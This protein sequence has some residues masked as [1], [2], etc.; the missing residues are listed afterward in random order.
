MF[1][2]KMAD[3]SHNYPS[4]IDTSII[5]LNN[6]A[7]SVASRFISREAFRYC[8]LVFHGL[9]QPG[10]NDSNISRIVFQFLLL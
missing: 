6:F 8:F 7:S 10:N 2:S 3:N 9:L 4:L 5:Y 1:N